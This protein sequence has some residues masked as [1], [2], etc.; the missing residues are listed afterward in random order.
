MFKK[1]QIIEYETRTGENY[2]QI[3]L[4]DFGLIMLISSNYIRHQRRRRKHIMLRVQWL[5]FMP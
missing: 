4:N 1:R 3:F 2:I 5:W